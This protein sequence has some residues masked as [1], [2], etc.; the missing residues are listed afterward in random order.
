MPNVFCCSTGRSD[1]RS[2]SPITVAGQCRI[3][4][5]L[6]PTIELLIGSHVIVRFH[7]LSTFEINKIVVAL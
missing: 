6:Q 7:L 3:F 2:L 4:T 1:F 5:G